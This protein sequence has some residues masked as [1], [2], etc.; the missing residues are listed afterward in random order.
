M[1]SISLTRTLGSVRRGA[2]QPALLPRRLESQRFRV[3]CRDSGSWSGLLGDIGMLETWKVEGGL[4][5]LGAAI[6]VGWSEYCAE[7]KATRLVSVIAVRRCARH[8]FGIRQGAEIGRRRTG[9]GKAKWNPGDRVGS[10]RTTRL[11]SPFP[12]RQGRAGLRGISQVTA[13]DAA[14]AALGA[15]HH[16]CVGRETQGRPGRSGRPSLLHQGS[17][18]RRRRSRRRGAATAIEWRAM[19]PEPQAVVRRTLVKASGA[20][21]WPNLQPALTPHSL[22]AH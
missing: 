10:G 12:A 14:C 9:V 17:G 18:N 1:Y 6:G 21:P 19:R 8:Q 4:A 5:R 11:V 22:P 2:G 20:A 7:L 16:R 13:E 3:W 15:L